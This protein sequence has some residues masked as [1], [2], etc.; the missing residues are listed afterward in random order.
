MRYLEVTE[1]VSI[2]KR[3]RALGHSICDR[4]LDILRY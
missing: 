2:F 4:D 3:A 1:V